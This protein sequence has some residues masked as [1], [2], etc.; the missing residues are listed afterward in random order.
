MRPANET[1]HHAPSANTAAVATLTGVSGF[2][3]V[4]CALSMSGN[5]APTAAVKATLTVGGSTVSEWYF[6]A[7]AFAPVISNLTARYECGDGETA[8]LTL[9]ALGVGK[10]GTATLGAHV[11]LNQPMAR[12]MSAPWRP[13]VR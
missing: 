4:I 11:R 10:S 7:S 12:R 8:V 9:P 5:D 13:A 2:K 6:P 3:W 1:A